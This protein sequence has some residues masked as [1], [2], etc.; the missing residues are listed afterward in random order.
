MP[1]CPAPRSPQH[2]FCPA[3][4]II[5]DTPAWQLWEPAAFET[6]PPSCCPS[7]FSPAREEAGWSSG[8]SQ[9]LQVASG[10]GGLWSKRGGWWADT[11]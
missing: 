5:Y 8:C 2:P 3:Q 9:S 10:P 4:E 11:P 6:Q 7:L 1:R